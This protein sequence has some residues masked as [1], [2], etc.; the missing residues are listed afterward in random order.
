MPDRAHLREVQYA[1]DSNF[2]ARFELH[3]RY[4]T[5]P[6][7]FHRWVFDQLRLPPDAAVL[8]LG[9]GP[10]HFWEANADRVPAA[11]RVVLTDF[12]AGMIA[13]AGRRLGDRAAYAV[14]DAEALPFAAGGFHAA[15]ANHML[16]HV[17]DRRRAA[18]ELA[19]VLRPD[20]V[21]LAAT[22]GADHLRELDELAARWAPDGRI[23][24]SGA[25]FSLENGAEQL[26]AGFGRVDVLE[27]RGELVVTEA[28]PVAA[29]VRSMTTVDW[30]VASLRAEVAELIER[31]GAFR[32]RTHA[33]VF[34]AGA[35][36]QSGT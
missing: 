4:G 19:R 22:N 21:L 11:W 2:N 16:Y 15:I 5:G 8:E 9:C 29:Y 23:A 32:I 12:S 17:P 13:A 36:I 26:M 7:R 35:P 20:G 1:D 14:A 3:R 31:H 27:H 33:G 24:R 34:V 28:E 6:A 18:R 30:D 25:A 10:G